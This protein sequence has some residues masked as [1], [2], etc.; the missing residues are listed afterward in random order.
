[1]SI[2]AQIRHKVTDKDNLKE[3]EEDLYQTHP[4]HSMDTRG[5]SNDGDQNK[6]NS[7]G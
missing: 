2:H 7:S 5:T 1:M 4:S 6:Y 3:L